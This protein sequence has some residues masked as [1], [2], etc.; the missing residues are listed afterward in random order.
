M[1]N[2]VQ[3]ELPETP[4]LTIVYMCLFTPNES[5]KIA[6]CYLINFFTKAFKNLIPITYSVTFNY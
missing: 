4:N 3:L 1:R 2:C 6:L 5:E